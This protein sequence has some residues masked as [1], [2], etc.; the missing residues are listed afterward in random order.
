MVYTPFRNRRFLILLATIATVLVVQSL[1]HGSTAGAV[2]ADVL[3]IL[4]VVAVLFIVFERTSQRLAALI[5]AIAAI[6]II[7]AHYALP[8]RFQVPLA[9]FH[10]GLLVVF[11]G[12]ALIEILRS[13]FAEK[14]VQT[15]DVLGAVCG[16][17]LVGIAW[18]NLYALGELLFPGGFSVAPAIHAELADWDGRRA[19]FTYFSFTIISS[20][21][22]ADVTAI[23]PPATTMVVAEVV[24][25][26]FYLAVVVAQIVSMKIA[27][28]V[29]AA[30]STEVAGE[31]ATRR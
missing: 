9:A 15:D 26:Q 19:L 31:V 14:P 4:V 24:F 20:L 22:Y 1:V 2:V 10:H 21:G 23:G 28:S 29:R 18:G 17:L 6:A 3:V 16:Y 7:V 13:L 12:W 5:T 25:G 11:L 27:Q 8:A 30:R